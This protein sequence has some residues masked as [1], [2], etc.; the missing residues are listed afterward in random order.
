MFQDSGRWLL[1]PLPNTLLHL[2]LVIFKSGGNRTETQARH[3]L[4]PGQTV[5]PMGTMFHLMRVTEQ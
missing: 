3:D 1:H 4:T 5:S 2:A